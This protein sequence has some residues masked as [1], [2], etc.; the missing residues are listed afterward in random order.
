M[1]KYE[2]GITYLER[3][4]DNE[5]PVVY[6]KMF[7]VEGDGTKTL[8]KVTYIKL[9]EPL[10]I[11]I[12]LED[13]PVGTLVFNEILPSDEEGVYVEYVTQVE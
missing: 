11:A 5:V 6:N 9:S 3:N 13:E 7:S 1:I 8:L 12:T 10:S 4:T 2:S